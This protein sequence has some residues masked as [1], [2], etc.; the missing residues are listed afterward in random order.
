MK[1]APTIDEAR[2]GIM[3]NEL[4]LP[5]IKTLWPQF[6]EQADR[7]GWPAARFLSAIAEHELGERTHRRIERHLAEAHLPPTSSCSGRSISIHS[8][9][10][11]IGPGRQKLLLD[12]SPDRC[13]TD[14]E[15]LGRL[16]ERYLTS[17]GTLALSVRWNAAVIVQEAHAGT[18]P[19]IALAG[20]LAS[21]VEHRRNCLI[22]RLSSQYGHEFDHVSVGSPPMLAGAVLAHA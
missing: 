5:T 4:R 15:D 20:L 18:G 14:V 13:F 2:L 6:A 19:I 11:A 12:H 21:P 1:G 8:A 3:L 22:R 10:L 16:H 9:H 7:E 17:F